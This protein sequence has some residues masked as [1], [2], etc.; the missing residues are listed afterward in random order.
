MPKRLDLTGS[1]FGS[2]T[3]LEKKPA[4]NKIVQWECSCSC[5]NTECKKIVQVTAQFLRKSVSESLYC[6]CVTDKEIYNKNNGLKWC[7]R[8]GET[9][10]Y[11]EFYPD[12]SKSDG[13]Y[14]SCKE[15]KL[16][17]AKEN[18]DT[19]RA[20]EEYK[21]N[22][23][24]VNSKCKNYYKEN[25]ERLLKEK[26]EYKKENK[27]AIYL[28]MKEW[29]KNNPEAV[30]ESKKRYKTLHSEEIKL[31]RKNNPYI[32]DK[33]KARSARRSV[34]KNSEHC[35][36][37]PPDDKAEMING[38]LH[39]VCTKCGKKFA[40]TRQAVASRLYLLKSTGR[41]PKF[42]CS[43]NCKNSCP[44][45]RS[46]PDIELR[47]IKTSNAR[48]CVNRALKELQC[49]EFGHNYCEKCG[50]IIDVELHHTAPISE[51]GDSAISSAGHI[52][53]CARC[54][55]TLHSKC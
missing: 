43:D 28:K 15:C 24:I 4:I 8:C 9:K 35:S 1:E 46:R 51:F 10:K 25:K 19:E 23:E 38:V 29:R 39:V 17:F 12:S 13:M 33:N 44:I 21:A 26:K 27:E 16:K 52:L 3:V 50:D 2:L 41:D 32:I 7:L 14:P 20:K 40:P 11:S 30:K 31:R 55:M 45:Y 22:K 42:Y 5:G 48:K 37:L 47:E 34:S 36:R 18:Y 6:G 54:H 49:D 53:L